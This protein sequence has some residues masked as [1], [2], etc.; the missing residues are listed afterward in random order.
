MNGYF[1]S[2]FGISNCFIKDRIYGPIS[3]ELFS[4]WLVD[5]SVDPES[6]QLYDL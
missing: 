4:S 1:L 6:F 3:E 5:D 2:N